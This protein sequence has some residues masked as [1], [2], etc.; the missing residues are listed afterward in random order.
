VVKEHRGLCNF[1]DPEDNTKVVNS[2]WFIEEAIKT[3]QYGHAGLVWAG[4]Q[5]PMPPAPT[6]HYLPAR[7]PAHVNNKT[8]G[9]EV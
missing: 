3:S 4:Y 2:G 9:N 6:S 7:P 5:Q 8:C 1:V